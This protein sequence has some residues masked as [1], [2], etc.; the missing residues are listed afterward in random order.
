MIDI[1]NL[2]CS[3]KNNIV[4]DGI[5]AQLKGSSVILGSNGSGKS[6]LAKTICLLLKYSGK[7]EL[8]GKDLQQFSKK[9]LAQKI[10][11]IPAK[12]DIYDEFINLKEFVL[13]G[14]FAYKENFGNY[15]KKDEIIADDAIEFLNIAHLKTQEMKSLSSGEAQLALIAQALTQQ[16]EIFIFD[17][18]TAN[19]DPAN[20]KL[21]AKEIKNLKKN[22]QVILITHDIHLAKY[23][24][25]SV[26]FIKDKQAVYFENNFFQDENLSML[27][28]VEFNNMV[29]NY[30]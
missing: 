23:F 4:L 3:Y 25:S 21:I 7:I 17:E 1:Q 11:Y 5:S 24:E 22:H 29:L 12:L 13:L 9:E 16:S 30:G 26:L 14:R 20:T 6:T 15:T 8:D 2:T 19:L 10:S 28:G 27:Y 18:P